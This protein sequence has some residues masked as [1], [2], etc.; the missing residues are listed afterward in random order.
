MKKESTILVMLL[1]LGGM[2]YGRCENRPTDCTVYISTQGND[3]QGDGTIQAPFYSLNKAVEG[4]LSEGT[5]T[6]FVCVEPGDYYLQ[7]PFTLRASSR[8]LVIRSQGKEKPRF[9]GGIRI[10]GWQKCENGMYKAFVPEVAQYGFSFEQF[11]VN[12]R[13]AVLARTPNTEW[14]FV[15]GSAEQPFV[16][17]LRCADYAVQQVSFHPADWSP[18]ADVADRDL[19]QIKFRFYHKWDITTKMPRYVEKDSSRIYMDGQGM[20]PWNPIH[21]GSRYFMYDYKA[22]LD[23]PGEWFLDRKESTVYYMPREGEDMEEAFCIAPVLE[24]WVLLQGTSQQPLQNVRFE[25]LSFQYSSYRM[26]NEG[27]EPAQASAHTKAAI[28]MDYANRITWENCD[29]LHTGTYAMWIRQACHNNRVSHCFLSDLGAGGIKVGEPYFRTN[30]EKVTS[31]NCIDNNIVTHAGLELPCG[32]G[33]ALFHTADNQ[34]THNEISDILYSGISVGWVWGY[35][36]SDALWT[37]AKNEKDEMVPIQ[38]KL[39]S[40]A[41]N[42]KVL[43]NHIHHIGWGELSDMGAVYTLGESPETCISYNVIHD[44][45]SYDYGGWGL[46]TDEGSTGVEMSYNLVYRCKSGGF[47]QHYG[48]ENKIVNNILAIGYT[49]QLQCTR[50]EEHTSFTFQRNI[51]LTEEEELFRNAW[52]KADIHADRNLYWNLKGKQDFCGKDFKQWK[53]EKEPH[54]IWADPLFRNPAEGDFTFRSKAAVRKVGFEPFDYT[55]AGVYGDPSWIEKAK[56]PKEREDEFTRLVQR[57]RKK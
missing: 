24:H 49:N 32:V 14:F 44:V 37:F 23:M 6:L 50:A 51:I 15:K 10:S 45:Y 16:N 39:V 22:A 1:L 21:E 30:R 41:V 3:L 4:R 27:E 47:H 52:E 33:I 40:P 34:V 48:K 28:Q 5:D 54:S 11:Y 25:N 36:Q 53:K 17:G 20:K 7:E 43:Y 56:L 57:L 46:Y 12:D 8:P 38:L 35:N 2:A 18:M 29:L 26:P 42:N 55:Q 9:I 31:G 13:R 19:K